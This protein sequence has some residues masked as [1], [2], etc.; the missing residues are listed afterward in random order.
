[1]NPTLL[2][3]NDSLLY[4]ELDNF[5]ETLKPDERETTK[6]FVIQKINLYT[7]DNFK[8]IQT[9]LSKI[10]K[11]LD[12]NVV[13]FQDSI[14]PSISNN[15][16]I[17]NSSDS[18]VKL[19]NN[20]I[21]LL[22]I[23]YKDNFLFQPVIHINLN[24]KSK[25]NYII[26]DDSVNNPQR[27][28]FIDLFEKETK[29]DGLVTID[30]GINTKKIIHE[31]T[32]IKYIYFNPYDKNKRLSIIEINIT[33]KIKKTYLLGHEINGYYNIYEDDS[34]INDLVGQVKFNENNTINVDWCEDYDPEK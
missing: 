4:T 33:T 12:K 7:V 20:D 32:Q 31:S 19:L 18:S 29:L 17:I 3:D 1:M 34:T 27:R 24:N 5:L 28:Y 13:I 30:T 26:D 22:H 16:N 9:I 14:A 2:N 6:E 10:S 11:W 15:Q 8:K 23:S 21:I 25:I